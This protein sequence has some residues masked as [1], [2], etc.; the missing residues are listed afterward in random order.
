MAAPGEQQRSIEDRLAALEGVAGARA[1]SAMDRIARY[2]PWYALSHLFVTAPAFLISVGVAYFTYVQARATERMQMA[3]VWPRVAYG[4]SNVSADG[5]RRITLSLFNQGVGP[6]RVRA[7]E[8]RY[9]G[10]AYPG[11]RQIVSACCTNGPTKV[12]LGL[13]TVRGEVIRPGEELLFGLLEPGMTPASV[14]DRFN[15][16]RMKLQ[17]RVCYCSV[18]DDCW[19]VEGS[20]AEPQPV[21]QCPANWVPFND[22]GLVARAGR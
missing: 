5:K 3:S 22:A 7:V 12:G 20:T 9:G 16:E 4:S 14:Y 17:V 10:R 15:A 18:F 6:A 1:P 2:A 13:S 21:A 8:V 11:L 19:T